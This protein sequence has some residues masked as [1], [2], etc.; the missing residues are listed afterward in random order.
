MSV[1]WVFFWEK[2]V[3]KFQSKYSNFHEKMTL[4]MSPAKCQPFRIELNV[5]KSYSVEN[6]IRS[7]LFQDFINITRCFLWHMQR[8]PCTSESISGVRVCKCNE[9][10]KNRSLKHNE[11]N[12][13]KPVSTFYGVYCG[14]QLIQGRLL[15]SLSTWFIIEVNPVS[16]GSRVHF[17]NND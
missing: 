6:I 2:I 7:I 9:H 16:Y 8:L 14:P 3:V 1:I 15:L 12:P 13:M 17:A 11:L 5:L 10:T 4:K